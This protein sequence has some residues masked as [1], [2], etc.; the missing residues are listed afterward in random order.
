LIHRLMRAPLPLR[1]RSWPFSFFFPTSPLRSPSLWRLSSPCPV[2][3]GFEVG[4]PLPWQPR[5]A[6][7]SAFLGGGM[8]ERRIRYGISCDK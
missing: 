4:H 3:F 7:E 6:G 8:I 5:L 1:S 2:H